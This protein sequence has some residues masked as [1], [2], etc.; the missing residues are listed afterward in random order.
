MDGDEQELLISA[1]SDRELWEVMDMMHVDDAV[2]VIEEMPAG[3]VKRILRHTDP[4]TRK[5]INEILR[6]PKDSAGSIMTTEYVDLKKH[7]TV[8]EAFDRIRR[9]GCD[10]ETI[11]NCYV[12]DEN[13]RLQGLVTVKELFLENYNETIENIMETNVIYTNTLDDQED[14]ARMFDKYGFMAITVVDN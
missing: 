9:I 8:S 6:Y 5:S 7:M 10:K 4:E 12:T 14:V 11:Y 3:V 2:D 1:F 13:R